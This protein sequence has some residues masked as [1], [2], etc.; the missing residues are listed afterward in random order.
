[1]NGET[2]IGLVSGI[3][4]F[5]GAAAIVVFVAMLQ[6]ATQAPWAARVC[7][8]GRGHRSGA[9][10]G[11]LATARRRN[12]RRALVEFIGVGFGLGLLAFD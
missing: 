2:K 5:L 3:G 8:Q 7:H 11:C 6:R 9:W 12:V 1:M 10:F 4:A